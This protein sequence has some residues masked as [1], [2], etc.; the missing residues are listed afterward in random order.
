[1]TGAISAQTQDGDVFG[2]WDFPT[3][4]SKRRKEPDCKALAH[5]FKAF[6]KHPCLLTIEEVFTFGS[7]HDTPLTAWQ[8]SAA[9]WSLRAT[10]TALGIH[11][12][13]TPAAAWKRHYQLWGLGREDGKAAAISLVKSQFPKAHPFLFPKHKRHQGAVC[14]PRPD[15][16]EAF[17]ITHYGRLSHLK[18]VYSPTTFE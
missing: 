12:Q 9:F 4:T 6:T 8:L 7:R 14:K 5:F 1:M 3:Q 17:L 2:I 11:V 18:S 16:A 13:T 10:A 15:R